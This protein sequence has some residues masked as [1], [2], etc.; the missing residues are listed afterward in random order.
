[1]CGGGS[2]VNKLAENGSFR[3]TRTAFCGLTQMVPIDLILEA[4][5]Q[6]KT[7][8]DDGDSSKALSAMC[9][10]AETKG[11]GA[12]YPALPGS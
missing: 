2:P 6:L 4:F 1:V 9:A 12:R 7:T 3:S 10:A 8:M 11:G 5:E